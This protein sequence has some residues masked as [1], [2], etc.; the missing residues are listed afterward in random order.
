MTSTV[1]GSGVEDVDTPGSDVAA[2]GLT[3]AGGNVGPAATAAKMMLERVC[4]TG[5]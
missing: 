2:G 4:K 5:S 3:A 1:L